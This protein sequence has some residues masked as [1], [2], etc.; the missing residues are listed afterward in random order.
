MK[1]TIK[2]IPNDARANAPCSPEK[3]I[4]IAVRQCGCPYKI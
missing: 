3:D 4:K 1:N 2:F